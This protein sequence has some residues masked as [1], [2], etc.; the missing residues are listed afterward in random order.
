[1]KKATGIVVLGLVFMLAFTASTSAMGWWLSDENPRSPRFDPEK[2]SDFIEANS[3]YFEELKPLRE[4]RREI[5]SQL[6]QECT[7]DDPDEELVTELKERM[8]EL[9]QEMRALR[10][11]H[12][13]ERRGFRENSRNNRGEGFRFNKGQHKEQASE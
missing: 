9:R 7:S 10:E 5:A 13:I 8:Q 3:E 2:H 12:G 6:R 11:N 1:M 4:E